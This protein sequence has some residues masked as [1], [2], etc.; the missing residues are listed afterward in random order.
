MLAALACVKY[1]RSPRSNLETSEIAESPMEHQ[2]KK[3]FY[4]YSEYWLDSW[5]FWRKESL[6][7]TEVQEY[8]AKD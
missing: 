4:N 1:F 2:E 8:I 6:Q 7:I 3:M 5:H